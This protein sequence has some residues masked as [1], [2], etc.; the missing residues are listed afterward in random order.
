[1]WRKSSV[2]ALLILVAFATPRLDAQ[3][4]GGPTAAA[5]RQAIETVWSGLLA[6]WK[7]GD[8]PAGMAAFFATDAVLNPYGRTGGT[9]VRGAQLSRRCSARFSVASSTSRST[10]T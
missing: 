5:D 8:D 9:T 2:L 7:S 6:L 10:T 1:M 3:V 4:A